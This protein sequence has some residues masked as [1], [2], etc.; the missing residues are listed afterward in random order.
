MKEIN[1]AK[2]LLDMRKRKGITQDDIAKYIGVSKASV[3][4]WE[5]GQSYPDITFLPQL[6]AYFNVSIDDLMGYE[7]QMVKADI[8]NLY[9][10]ISND[11]ATKPFDDVLERCRKVVKKYYSCFPLLCQIAA[12]LVNY[13]SL[14][15]DKEKNSSI[16]TEAKELCIRVKEESDDAELARQALYLE[17]VCTFMLGN[18]SEVLELLGETYE[19]NLSIEP[20][21]ASA[22]QMTGKNKEAKTVLQVGMYERIIGILG[23]APSYLMLYADDTE[24]FEEMYRRTVSIVEAFNIKELHPSVLLNFY[25]SA[26]QGYIASQNTGKALE[27]LEKYTEIASENMNHLMLKGDEF[28]D[29]LDSWIDEFA[30]GAD[31]PRDEKSIRLSVLEAIE[32]NPA[33]TILAEEQRYKIVVEILKNN[34]MEVK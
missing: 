26:A 23:I 14:A 16:L 12:L 28:F 6:A 15:K 3:S 30:L 20:L 7:P 19:S 25:L 33:F 18:P 27:M 32:N 34:C 13:S 4:K 2:V 21:R 29:L 22:Y 9:R 31:A 1:I 5:T 24:K 11:F 10:E 17:A 8:R